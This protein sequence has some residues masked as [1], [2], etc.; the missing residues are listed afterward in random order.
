M[1]GF[2]QRHK[3]KLLAAQRQ[4]LI[5]AIK[6][7]ATTSTACL[8]VAAGV[9]PIDLYLERCIHLYKIK[10]NQP[11]ILEERLG[12]DM[13][14]DPDGSMVVRNMVDAHLLQ[15]WQTRWDTARTG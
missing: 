7:N 4:V 5:R 13:Y 12:A 11:T 15:K 8:P 10:R 3:K 1:A 2:L 6:A 9:L 14:E